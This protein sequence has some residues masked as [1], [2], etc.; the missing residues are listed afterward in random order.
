MPFSL[1][2]QH[3]SAC[4][5]QGLAYDWACCFSKIFF[6]CFWFIWKNSSNCP[7][8]GTTA[9]ISKLPVSQIESNIELFQARKKW[10]LLDICSSKHV[11]IYLSEFCPKVM[12]F[13]LCVVSIFMLFVL[14]FLCHCIQLH[15]TFI[16]MCLPF[17]THK[18]ED[19]F[20]YFVFNNNLWSLFSL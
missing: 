14:T 15:Y 11:H 6:W 20:V 13:E 3:S 12:Q 19:I 4:Y 17:L 10:K 16:L 5:H 18:V 2:K 1:Q 8:G 9:P 7:P